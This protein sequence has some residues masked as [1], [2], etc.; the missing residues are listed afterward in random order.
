MGVA[1]R[2]ARLVLRRRAV[3]RRR[4]RDRRTGVQLI[5]EGADR[6]RRRRRVDP[7][8]RRAGGRGRGAA[9]GHPRD[10]GAGRTRSRLSIDT[11]EA[12]GGPRRRSP[13]APPWSTTSRPRSGRWPAELG[14]GWVAMHMAGHARTP[15]RS[16]RATTTWSPRSRPSS[17]SRRRADAERRRRRDLDRPGHRLRQDGR[18][19]PDPAAAP[20]R[21]RRAR[22][23]RCVVGTSRKGFLGR[24]LGRVRRG[25]HETPLRRRRRSARGAR[26]PPPTWAHGRRARA[27]SASTM[28]RASPSRQRKSWQH[29]PRGNEGQVGPGHPAPQLPLDHQGPARRVRA[30]GRLR[31]QPSPRPPPG[32]DH[33]DP[34]AGLHL[35]DLADPVAAQPAQLRRARRHLAPPALRRRRRRARVPVASC[36]PELKELAERR[37]A[38]CSCTATSSATASAA[39]WP[40]TCC[41]TAWSTRGRKPSRSSSR[42]PNASSGPVGREL[43]VRGRS[44]SRPSDA[45]SCPM[46]PLSDA[47]RAAR[48]PGV[49]IC[50][51]LP[52]EQERAQPL[53]VDLDVERRPRRPPAR[54]DALDDTV[55]YGAIA[56][57][58][59]RVHRDRAVRAARAAGGSASPRSCWPT[60]GSTPSRSRCASCGRR[61]P[62]TST[63]SGVRIAR[64]RA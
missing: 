14:V 59:E 7:A 4:R 28:C 55:D 3:P 10:R 34:R 53:E 60:R 46:F 17:P 62:S 8:G 26:S 38:R 43:V 51:A 42:S 64:R 23:T 58:V 22:A 29:E 16:I 44:A 40:A 19:Q 33:L 18:A 45:P 12:G 20:R 13:P 54:T 1:Q 57:D 15:C 56:A 27:W 50:G 31:R 36:Y 25:R 49:G 63:P 2:D 39:P 61:C 5:A 6:R 52:E 11:R 21:A 37:A 47:H 41:G 9:P 24:L 35:R 32:R 30:A 48:A